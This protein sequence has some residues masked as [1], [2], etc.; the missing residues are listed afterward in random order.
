[1]FIYCMLFYK[2]IKL[3]YW[4][5][6]KNII[7]YNFY[8][9]LLFFL[10]YKSLKWTTR[11]KQIIASHWRADSVDWM[12]LCVHCSAFDTELQCLAKAWIW[13][14]Y[15]S[16]TRKPSSRKRGLCSGPIFCQSHWGDSSQSPRSRFISKPTLISHLELW[17]TRTLP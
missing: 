3:L 6:R 13:S 2:D 14:C 8:Y 1:M 11:E 15:P 17:L 12:C 10:Q 16:I 9:K 5:I 7:N 4:K